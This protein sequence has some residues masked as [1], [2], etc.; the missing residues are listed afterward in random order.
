MNPQDMVFIIFFT[1]ISGGLF[2]AFVNMMLNFFKEKRQSKGASLGAGELEAMI[3]RAVE[4]GN[5]SLHDRLDDLEERLDRVDRGMKGAVKALPAAQPSLLV[6]E[7]IEPGI[8]SEVRAGRSR[9]R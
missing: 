9:V 1:V 2:L 6:D 4:A 3:Q 7:V 8:A 5:A